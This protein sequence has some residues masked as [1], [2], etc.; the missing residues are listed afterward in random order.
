MSDWHE[1]P[2]RYEGRDI[3]SSTIGTF[4]RSRFRTLDRDSRAWSGCRYVILLLTLLPRALHDR[5]KVDCRIGR[6]GN[7]EIW[8]TRWTSRE[9]TEWFVKINVRIV[10]CL[11][12]VLGSFQDFLSSG[13]DRMIDISLK[14]FSYDRRLFLISPVSSVL[15][16]KINERNV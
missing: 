14:W 8:K 11:Q 9:D 6:D 1:D 7:R 13:F 12:R 5:T 16:C 3:F 2:S 4:E 15:R 10:R